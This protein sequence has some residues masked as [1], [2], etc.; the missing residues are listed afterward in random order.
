MTAME[1]WHKAVSGS[2]A[3]IALA[4]EW[5]NEIVA[6]LKLPDEKSYALRV[7]AEE[8]LTNIFRH[9]GASSRQIDLTLSRYADRVE[10]AVEDDGVPF[11]VSAATP[12]R[13]DRPI[14]N[15]Q[16]GGLGIQLIHEFADR[17][18]YSRA[19]LRNRVIAEFTLS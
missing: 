4:S 15:A 17:L 6:G 11:D 10:L 14:E 12:R 5:V 2:L 8:I 7:C 9:A 19:G 13:V 16:P 3:D 1:T 18:R